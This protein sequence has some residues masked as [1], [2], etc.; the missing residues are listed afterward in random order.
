M[1]KVVPWAC[2]RA[3]SSPALTESTVSAP[4]WAVTMAR[5]MLIPSPVEPVRRSREASARAKRSKMRSR[6][7][8]S[9]PGPSSPMVMTQV[10]AASDGAAAGDAAVILELP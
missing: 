5:A 3:G 2:G 7:S 10:P 9:M 8:G 6:T 4:R 1:V